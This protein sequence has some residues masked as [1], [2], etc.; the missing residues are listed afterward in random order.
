[1]SSVTSYTQRDNIA[2]ITLNSPPVNGL[3]LALRQGILEGFEQATADSSV[4]AIVIASAGKI[5]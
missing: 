3:G 1:M 5:F 4:D 2:V